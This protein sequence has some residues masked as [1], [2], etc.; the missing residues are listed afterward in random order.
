M[1]WITAFRSRPE[2]WYPVIQNFTEEDQQGVWKLWSF[3]MHN[4]NGWVSLH[5]ALSQHP[6]SL[7]VKYA[8]E[9]AIEWC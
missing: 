2:S 6:M 8:Q 7:L 9:W 4:L 5:V 3:D 1:P